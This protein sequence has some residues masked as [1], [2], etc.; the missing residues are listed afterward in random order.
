[1]K[2]SVI[3]CTRNR[4]FVIKKCIDA[5]L[6]NDYKN[7]EI[8]V[9]DQSDNDLTES[10]I[11]NISSKRIRYY[12][13]NSIGLS[14]SRNYGISKAC[15]TIVAFTDDDCIVSNNWLKNIF[16][17]FLINKSVSILYGKV[18]PY[19]RNRHKGLMCP[20]IKIPSNKRLIT[21]YISSKNK[22]II[23][24]GNNLSF[25]KNVF[26]EY[27]NFK[28]W[29]GLGTRA[30]AAEDEEYVYRL[31]SKGHKLLIDP[32]I[33][34]YHNRWMKKN[35]YERHDILYARGMVSV[36]SYY[37]L[38]GDRGATHYLFRF[39]LDSFH[40]SVYQLVKYLRS[41]HFKCIYRHIRFCLLPKVQS[42]LIG[43]IIGLSASVT[44]Q[45]NRNRH[46]NC[47]VFT[48]LSFCMSQLI[49]LI[50][51]SLSCHYS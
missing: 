33:V 36:L 8:I 51:H 26:G 9:I 41:A 23:V 42:Y 7:F 28:N 14:R 34:V 19:A 40:L 13:I 31:I 21:S 38:H 20:Y 10:I 1:M 17:S 47:I 18:L 27:E 16:K 11:K 29:L 49:L 15:G 50:H 25:R 5:L 32:S 48:T 22:T 44:E 2:I 37:A 46:G 43:I 45:I 24:S 30:N 4:D 12:H 6:R 39:L 35:E 3:V